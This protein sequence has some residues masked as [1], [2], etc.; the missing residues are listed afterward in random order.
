MPTKLKWLPWK[1]EF[2]KWCSR[3]RCQGPD[4][5]I[6]ERHWFCPVLRDVICEICCHYDEDA[7]NGIRGSVP[8]DE[9]NPCEQVK[10]KHYLR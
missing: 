5:L 3:C 4:P 1:D 9:P 8:E 6:R 7:Y 10:C 2:D